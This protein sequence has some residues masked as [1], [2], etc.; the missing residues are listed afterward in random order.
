MVV[1]LVSRKG[2]GSFGESSEFG[3]DEEMEL[4]PQGTEVSGG[5]FD[6]FGDVELVEF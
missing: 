2:R 5:C 4:A 1:K 6:S 3:W